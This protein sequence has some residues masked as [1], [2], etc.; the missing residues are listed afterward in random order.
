MFNPGLSVFVC[1]AECGNFM[2]AEEC[3]QFHP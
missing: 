3:G 2:K 1:V